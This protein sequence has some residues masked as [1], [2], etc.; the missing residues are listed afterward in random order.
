MNNPFAMKEDTKNFFNFIGK[1]ITKEICKDIANHYGITISEA[2]DEVL[3]VDA[4]NIM[5]YITK[6]R[7]A[8]HLFYKKYKA[9]K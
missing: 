6:N 5:D 8:V 1:D 3:D 4:E 7:P 9:S 2:F